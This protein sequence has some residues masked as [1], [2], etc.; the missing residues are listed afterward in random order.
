MARAFVGGALVSGLAYGYM[1]YT[2][3]ANTKAMKSSIYDIQVE[4]PGATRFPTTL[5]QK[6]QARMEKVKENPVFTAIRTKWNGCILQTRDKLVDIK[7]N[8]PSLPKISKSLTGGL[9][10]S[11]GKMKESKEQDTTTQEKTD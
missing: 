1:H 7:N 4:I 8:P 11:E 10:I 6:Y 3:S 2:I 5:K 9:P